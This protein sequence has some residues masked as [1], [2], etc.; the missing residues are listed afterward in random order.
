MRDNLAPTSRRLSSDGPKWRGNFPERSDHLIAPN[1]LS[2]YA[3][4][5]RLLQHNCVTL[6]VIDYLLFASVHLF[7]MLQNFPVMN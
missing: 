7:E 2:M 3:P 5:Y 4:I 6:F 1:R